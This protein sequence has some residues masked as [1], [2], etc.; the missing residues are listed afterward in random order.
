MPT[1][2][3]EPVSATADASG[4]IVW[5]WPTVS[6]GFTWYVAV[7]IPL[8]P[9][10]STAFVY[11]TEQPVVQCL[12]PQPS[13]GVEVRGGTRLQ[14]KGSGF[15]KTAASTAW[16]IGS[17]S[18]GTPVGVVPTG[19]STITKLTKSTTVV[20]INTLH[21]LP[22][23]KTVGVFTGRV[24]LKGTATAVAIIPATRTATYFE[25]LKIG[26]AVWSTTANTGTW[27][28]IGDSSGGTP[29]DWARIPSG[30]TKVMGSFSVAWGNAW[31]VRVA[32]KATDHVNVWA[33]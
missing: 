16:A 23:V 2:L 12:G 27:L 3:R 30:K 10:T 26:W 19:P 24:A 11:L 22:I 4:K 28:Y 5:T 31:V 14:V 21:V 33:A 13:A 20:T 7:V 9:S 18:R 32:G 6:V 8:A 25:N 17:V 1:A 29:T 15:T